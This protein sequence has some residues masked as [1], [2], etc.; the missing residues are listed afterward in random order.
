MSDGVGLLRELR[1]WVAGVALDYVPNHAFHATG[2]A[3][4]VDRVDTLLQSP[5]DFG[6]Q[7]L[8]ALVRLMWRIHQVD[9]DGELRQ[10]TLS[11]WH[12]GAID[13]LDRAGMGD[14]RERMIE[15]WRKEQSD[16]E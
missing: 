8:S 7:A 1:A 3:G 13:L 15:Q 2:G 14:W 4:I 16:D 5:G 10:I 12:D 6:N 9:D 11:S